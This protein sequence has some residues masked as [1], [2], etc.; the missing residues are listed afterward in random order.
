MIATT[1]GATAGE[2]LPDQVVIAEYPDLM[3]QLEERR[4]ALRL[5]KATGRRTEEA[6]RADPAPSRPVEGR[7]PQCQAL[8]AEASRDARPRVVRGGTGPMTRVNRCDS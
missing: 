8:C 5:I 7:C 1:T 6:N 4:C 3:P 2:A